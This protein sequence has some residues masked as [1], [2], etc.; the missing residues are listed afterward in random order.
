MTVEDMI[1]AL[2]NVV[3]QNP[4]HAKLPIVK[5]DNDGDFYNAIEKEFN[6]VGAVCVDECG[7]F[8]YDEMQ[9]G[10]FNA[11]FIC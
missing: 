6:T 11:V 4:S 10:N 5:S 7:G 1:I 2:Q 9:K 3:K 8:N